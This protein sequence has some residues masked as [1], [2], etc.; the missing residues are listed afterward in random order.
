MRHK[1]IFYLTPALFAAGM[2][3]SCACLHRASSSSLYDAQKSLFGDSLNDSVADIIVNAKKVTCTLTSASPSAA[4]RTDSVC[5][6]TDETR[7]IATYLL[8]DSSNFQTDKVIYAPF[9]S[10]ASYRF[11]AGKKRYVTVDLDFG[12]SKWVLCDSAKQKV[13]GG[14]MPVM[15]TQWL[16]LTRLLFPK[17]E[18]LKLLS[19]N[20]NAVRQ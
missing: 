8:L 3:V 1:L 12:T 5:V 14:D 15:N 9:Q 11:E 18:T 2:C 7:S 4:P 20:L 17:D 10:W 13:C 19:D 16:R 6:L